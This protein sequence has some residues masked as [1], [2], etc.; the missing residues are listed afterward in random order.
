MT[1]DLEVLRVQNRKGKELL[2]KL[3]GVTV[4]NITLGS[5]VSV[6]IIKVKAKVIEQKEADQKIKVRLELKKNE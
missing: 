6:R 3:S 1:D 4:R 5:G 2:E